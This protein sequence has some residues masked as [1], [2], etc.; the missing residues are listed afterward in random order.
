MGP[1]FHDRELSTS[2][3]VLASPPCC[4]SG[5]ILAT[6]L[7]H[8]ARRASSA[9]SIAPTAFCSLNSA[10]IS[11]TTSSAA[12]IRRRRAGMVRW[13]AVVA[14]HQVIAEWR[15]RARVELGGVPERPSSDD[16]ARTA[17]DRLSVEVVIEGFAQLNDAGR[18]V[19]LSGT[20]DSA[21]DDS[22]GRSRT[23]MRWFRVRQQLAVVAGRVDS[24]AGG[25]GHTC[26]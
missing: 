24:G 25:G 8:N 17:E 4:S 14:W 11:I 19:V 12:S 26:P 22:A 9:G 21:A 7:R 5:A 18:S 16:P 20:A 23:K 10:R 2:D 3:C 6:N 13:V 15:R 1:L